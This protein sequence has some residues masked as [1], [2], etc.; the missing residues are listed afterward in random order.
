MGWV[1]V[2]KHSQQM[3]PTPCSDKPVLVQGGFTCQ[4]CHS[5]VVAH[6]LVRCVRGAYGVRYVV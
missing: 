2:G 3:C 1:Q 4:T 5:D 6:T